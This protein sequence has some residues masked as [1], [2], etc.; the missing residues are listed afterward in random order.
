[1]KFSK[2]NSL[3]M[4]AVNFLKNILK[5]YFYFFYFFY[6][7]IKIIKKYFKK[8]IVTVKINKFYH[9]IFFKVFLKYKHKQ[10]LKY[11]W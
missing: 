1:M 7:N 2:K 10:G 4:H 9:L 3:F 11:V 8:H 6:H 5:K